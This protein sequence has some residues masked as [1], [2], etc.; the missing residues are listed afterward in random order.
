MHCDAF[1]TC[2]LPVWDPHR[3]SKG[4][5]AVMLSGP[6]SSDAGG[7]SCTVID[8]AL[9]TYYP[10]RGRLCA[11]CYDESHLQDDV[12]ELAQH[13]RMH[14][15]SCQQHTCGETSKSGLDHRYA[16]CL[17]QTPA[18]ETV[19]TIVQVQLRRIA[20][21]PGVICQLASSAGCGPSSGSSTLC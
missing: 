10:S 14:V 15:A 2:A 13:N 19:V 7:N 5:A 1:C 8:E 6:S 9:N 20:D 17:R 4:V 3:M 16:D 12:K 11:L 21:R 18:H